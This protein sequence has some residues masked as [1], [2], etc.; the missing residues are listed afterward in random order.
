MGSNLPEPTTLNLELLLATDSPLDGSRL[1]VLGSNVPE[2][3]T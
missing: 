3:T 2:P 1:W